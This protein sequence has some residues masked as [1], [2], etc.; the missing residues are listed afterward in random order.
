VFPEARSKKMPTIKDR[1]PTVNATT[2]LLL[3][4]ANPFGRVELMDCCVF[5]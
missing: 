1:T 5:N 4:N 2:S 3:S